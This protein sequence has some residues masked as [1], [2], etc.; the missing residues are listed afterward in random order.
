MLKCRVVLLAMAMILSCGV[1]FAED[2][3]GSGKPIEVNG[4][5]V[6]FFHKEKKIIGKGNVTIDYEGIKL[7]CDRITVYS[8]TKDSEA[9]GHVVLKTAGSELKGEKIT[10]NFG[11]KVGE[12]LKARAQSGDGIYS[13]IK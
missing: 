7:T 10:Y 12:I 13:E 2:G 3:T 6:E 9:E 1:A 5:Q 8:E 11:T 4:D